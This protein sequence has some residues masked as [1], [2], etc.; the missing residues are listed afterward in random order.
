MNNQDNNNTENLDDP[1]KGF[2]PEIVD[3]AALMAQDTTIRDENTTTEA[4][5]VE[6][7]EKSGIEID[8]AK[9][10]QEETPEAEI[11]DDSDLIKST[12]DS[13]KLAATIVDLAD[14][15]LTSSSK[16]LYSAC[17]SKEDRRD[18][19]ALAL[20]YREHKL[21]K[22]KEALT[23]VGRETEVL[24]LYMDCEDY[25]ENMPLTKDEKKS[26]IE[27]LSEILKNTK[28]ETTPQNALIIAAAMVAVPRIMPLVPLYLQK[29]K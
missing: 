11:L 19:K 24:E 13:K 29:K 22:S 23:L 9:V 16:H 8:R 17:L 5:T 18:M 14:A 4:V 7:L 21:Q 15:V 26:L 12:Y 20:K 3:L 28:M 27:P 1:N 2:E 6:D 10:I 25:E